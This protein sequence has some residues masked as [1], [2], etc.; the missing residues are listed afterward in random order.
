MDQIDQTIYIK[1]MITSSDLKTPRF[2]KIWN[3]P[4]TAQTRH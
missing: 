4:L 3:N 1:N 2:F